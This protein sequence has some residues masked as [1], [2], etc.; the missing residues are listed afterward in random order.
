MA[1]VL[2]KLQRSFNM[3]KIR[4]KNTKPE[5][6]VRSIVYRMGF[7][8]RLHNKNLP[9]K[10]DI[11]LTRHK[12]IIFVHGC[13]WHLHKCRYG[14]V[15][16]ATNVNF[17]EKKRSDN[18]ERDKRNIKELKKLGWDVLVIWECELKKSSE[19]TEKKIFKFLNNQRC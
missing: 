13:F 15:K 8:Y 3:S 19:K 18:Q 17:W 11:V 10:P 1:D 7:R 12:K 5:I 4:D 9:G 16:P 14:K 2:T 6:I